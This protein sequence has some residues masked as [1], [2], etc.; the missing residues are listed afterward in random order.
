MPSL[1]HI[2]G[3]RKGQLTFPVSNIELARWDV[4]RK[5]K[6]RGLRS[7]EQAGLISTR[8]QGRRSVEVTILCTAGETPGDEG[9]D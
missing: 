2:L 4:D 8:Q 7:L 5:T 6:H 3:K 1:W 9:I